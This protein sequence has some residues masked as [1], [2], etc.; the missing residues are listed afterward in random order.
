MAN[1]VKLLFLSNEMV[2]Y[3]YAEPYA[4]GA[5][6]AL[7][8]LF[9]QYAS[10]VHIN[11][12]NPSVFAFWNAVLHDTDSLCARIRDV[13]VTVDEW[14]RQKAVQQATDPEQ[15]DLAVSTFFL[16]RTNRSGIIEGGI[17][18]GKN[19]TG[20]WKLDARFN[21]DDLIRR[22]SKIARQSE[23][24]TLTRRDAACY[25][26]DVVPTLPRSTF[27]YLDPPYFVKGRGLY[28]NFYDPDDHAEIS[29]AM[30]H[31]ERPWLVSYDAA[32]EIIRLYGRHSLLTYGL[33][34]SAAD[35]YSGAEVMFFSRGLIRPDVDSPAKVKS[36]V[37]SK[38][39]MSLLT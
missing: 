6:V 15:L 33:S 8:L 19:Q 1:Y 31:V 13:A 17:I 38:L 29:A 37:V 35:R 32:P 36:R 11:D 16:N 4:G 7:S 28:Q 24:I 5:S 27:L 22:I 25:L 20:N 34:Y 39:R 9:E 21:K 10:R 12:L 3:D 14:H 18:G 26:R 2:G 30:D 23:R